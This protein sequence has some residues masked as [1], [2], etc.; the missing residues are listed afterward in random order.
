MDRLINYLEH[1]RADKQT[2]LDLIQ[3][4]KMTPHYQN[5]ERQILCP[6]D[7]RNDLVAQVAG[8]DELLAMVRS[9]SLSA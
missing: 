9:T 6:E 8:L 2:R 5:G 3:S 1:E 4:G 7:F